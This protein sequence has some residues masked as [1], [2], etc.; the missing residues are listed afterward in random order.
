MGINVT[1]ADVPSSSKAISRDKLATLQVRK[2]IFHDVPRT[3][4]GQEQT[5]TLSEV[6]CAID[7]GKVA[8]LKDKLVRVLGSSAAYDMELY[9]KPESSIPELV[10]D[11]ISSALSS[12]KFVNTS[13]KMASAL[14][15]HQ[16]GSA[17]PGLLAVVSCI[18][19][20]KS[21]LALLKLEREEGAQLK[22]SNR[23]GKQ[24]FEMDVIADLVLTDGTRLFKAALFARTGPAEDDV[25]VLACDGQRSSIWTDELAQFWI[26]FLGC[27]LLEAPRIATKKFFDATLE[28]INRFV[29]EPDV[30]NDMY[31][32]IVSEMK[33][34]KIVFAPK[35]FIEDYVPEA[36]REA[37]R[38]HLEEQNVNMKQ[39]H[40][41]TTEI[42]SHLKRRSLQT[43]TG[44]RIT[45][46]AEANSVVDV[47]ATHIVIADSV[48]S[49]G[50]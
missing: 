1:S 35:K 47:Q 10:A 49:V 27:K 26:R 46:P 31:D 19:G 7:P 33:S 42:K 8:L 13:Q 30:K 29:G 9:P 38:K 41:D 17:S 21:G 50:P 40:V 14:L 12:A 6:E 5:P 37:F 43:S 25:A 18:V 4:R 48:V 34:Q 44:V 3:I 15:K 11:S 32:M 22:L 23:G 39:F 28:Y 45:V 24:T 16:P 20:G 2:V 36:H